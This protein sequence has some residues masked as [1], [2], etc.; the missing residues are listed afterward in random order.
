M[1][2]RTEKQIAIAIAYLVRAKTIF[3][4]LSESI[5]DYKV[6]VKCEK[7]AEYITEALEEIQ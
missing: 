7:A 6:A 1:T 5:T 3:E 2:N 4:D